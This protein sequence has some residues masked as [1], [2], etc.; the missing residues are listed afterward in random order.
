MR[1]AAASA[2]LTSS[3]DVPPSLHLARLPPS[4]RASQH[5]DHIDPSVALLHTHYLS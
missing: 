4:P 5:P 1:G 2:E 3:C